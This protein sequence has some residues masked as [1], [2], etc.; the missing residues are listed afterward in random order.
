[1][2]GVWWLSK[3]LFVLLLTITTTL[4]IIT[5]LILI[6]LIM[7]LAA[8]LAAST[9]LQRPRSRACLR[10]QTKTTPYAPNTKFLYELS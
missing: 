9:V 5:C 8:Q 6:D 3:I 1:M 7:L 2:L 4:A 10:G